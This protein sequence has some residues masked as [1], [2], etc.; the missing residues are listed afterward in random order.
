[1]IQGEDGQVHISIEQEHCDRV[2]IRREI[3]YL[4]TITGEAHVFKLDG[5]VQDDPP[6]FGETDQYKTS[7]KFDDSTLRIEARSNTGNTL[8]MIYARTPEGDLL[9]EAVIN[10]RSGGPVVAKRQK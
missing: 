10:G 1:M 6:W 2:T 8:T 4:G 7:A 9:E 3:G 5:T